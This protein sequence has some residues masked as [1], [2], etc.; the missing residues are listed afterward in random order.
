MKPSQNQDVRSTN[1][2]SS[3]GLLIFSLMIVTAPLNRHFKDA[4]LETAMRQAEVVGYQVA[5]IYREAIRGESR[6][7]QPSK[8]VVASV[9]DESN[10]TLENIRRIGT[11]GSD[12]WGQP[13]HYKIMNAD[14]SLGVKV[15]VWSSG[16]NMKIETAELQTEGFEI[17]NQPIYSGDDLGVVINM[18][19]N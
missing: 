2:L 3:F 12:P 15:V 1:L 5:Q 10:N 6:L 14:R 8:R 13:F 19:H 4:R 11:M 7:L 9:D 16:P 18:A 17:V